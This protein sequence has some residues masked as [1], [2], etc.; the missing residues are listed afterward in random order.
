MGSVKVKRSAGFS[1]LEL[2]LS[3]V[4]LGI[5]SFAVLQRNVDKTEDNVAKAFG[6][7]VSL[8][9]NAVAA[10]IADEGTSVPAGTF[11]GFDWLKGPGC[12]GSATKDYLPCD[13]TPRLPFNIALET[14]VIYA[15]ATPG[16]PCP[17]PV[18]HVCAETRL[19]V[20]SVNGQERLD[21]AAEMLHSTQGA[22][23]AVRSTQQDFRMTDLGQ[24]Q[25]STRGS[26]SPPSEYL[27]R[28]GVNNWAGPDPMNLG[29]NNFVAVD[30]IQ[31]SGELVGSRFIDRDDPAFI[32]DPDSGT[33]LN[34][35]R[36][37]GDFDAPGGGSLLGHAEF[38]AGADVE[39]AATF[40][41]PA[42]FQDKT[43]FTGGDTQFNAQVDS[44][45][46]A[47]AEFNEATSQT[48]AD[49]N[50]ELEII[51]VG[52]IGGACNANQE[53]LRFNS[54]G[55]LLECVSGQWQYAGI[56]TRKGTITYY[57]LDATNGY[58]EFHWAGDGIDIPGYHH[59][60]STQSIESSNQAEGGG[61]RVEV[62]SGQ[63]SFGRHQ[64]QYLAHQG[65]QDADDIPL[66]LQSGERTVICMS[67]GPEPVQPTVSTRTNTAPTGSVSCTTG[68]VGEPFLSTLSVSDPDTPLIYQ[69]STSGRCSVLHATETQ[70]WIQ[71]STISG[72]CTVRVRVTDYYNA[73]RTI[74]SSCQV[75][76]VS[77]AT[78]EG[79][80]SC[81]AGSCTSGSAYDVT[82]SEPSGYDSRP[83]PDGSGPWDPDEKWWCDGRLR[84]EQRLLRG[85]QQLPVAGERQLQ[86]HHQP[87]LQ[88]QFR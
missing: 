1:L 47:P 39:S 21:L 68:F 8:Y 44:T 23:S 35:F 79:V 70:A 2:M 14:E 63:D 17:D 15:T 83:P 43:T 56:E 49:F 33:T 77:P 72:T 26:Q 74:S 25:V 52:V 55:E 42:E 28:D 51:G 62:N 30:D 71:R 88:W 54:A 87:L 4:A 86:W 9:S 11:T 36:G 73:S 76:S 32:V 18:G 22:T 80:C 19:S 69:W 82:P 13:W 85:G 40:N 81:S 59:L 7:S 48:I 37:A 34:Q 58:G 16:D 6:V 41:A 84:R 61:A 78:V 20:P 10:Y 67:L 66:V 53:N 12:G 24:V 31:A 64:W 75:R 29:D 50:A 3:L 45:G 65:V 5:V 57:S 60:C 27:R 46:S 38:G